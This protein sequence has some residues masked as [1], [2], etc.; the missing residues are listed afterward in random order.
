MNSSMINLEQI[1]EQAVD[2]PTLPNVV[3]RI[4]ELTQDA[5]STA[6]DIEEEILK[7]QALTAK[8]LKLANSAFYSYPRRISSISQATVLLGFQTIK[9]ITL[10]AS[11]GNIL[12]KELKGY[13]L[14]EQ[15]LLKQSQLC[16]MVSSMIAKRIKYKKVENAYIAGLLRDIGKLV[17][18]HYMN[19]QYVN[20]INKVDKE[21]ITFLDAE[22]AIL[23]FNHAE[24]GSIIAEKW[25]LPAELVEAIAC[26]HTPEL[27]KVNKEITAIV[28]VADAI[29]MMTGIGMGMDGLAYNFSPDAISLLGLTEKDV[30]DILSDSTEL[31]VDQD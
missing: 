24:V 16:A 27:A 11:V 3:I 28:H 12:S 1:I 21:N 9:S 13:A 4:M 2:I 25:N 23:G 6:K 14:G 20:V 7:D 15:T 17:L 26:H 30:E 10:T 22:E 5:N 31:L 19:E 29:V 8:V 18:N